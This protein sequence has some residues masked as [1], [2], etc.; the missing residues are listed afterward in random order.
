MMPTTRPS[1][2]PAVWPWLAATAVLL[3]AACGGTDASGDSATEA[4][5]AAGTAAQSPGGDGAAADPLDQSDDGLAVTPASFDLAVG[6]DRRFLAG[7]SLPQQ[8]LVAGGEVAME[9]LYLGEQGAQGEPEN[10][11]TTTGTFLPVP[12][13][14]PPADLGGPTAIDPADG[15]GVYE[16][17]MTF[18][19]P[20]FYAVALQASVADHGLLTGVGAFQVAAEQQVPGVGEPAPA[21]ANPTVAA[22][23]SLPPGTDATP[24][25]IDS[26]AAVGDDQTIPDPELHDTSVADALAAGRPTVVAV[27]TPVYCVSQFCGPIVDSIA[28]LEAE[29][30]DRAEFVHLEVWRDFAAN[31]LND[32]AAAYIQTATGGNEPWVFLVGADGTIE[33][34]WDNVLDLEELRSRLDALPAA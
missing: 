4:T 26:R 12:G 30:G 17:T 31:E 22:D 1:P 11:G 19:R 8:G 15:A 24:G 5:G 34:R 20:G 13:K 6:E 21:P 10:L 32:A 18:D 14:E 2:R 33:A 28:Q 23:G 3:L 25:A 16:T 7:A 9:F 29:Y 27:A